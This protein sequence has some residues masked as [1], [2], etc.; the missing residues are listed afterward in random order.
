[1]SEKPTDPVDLYWGEDSEAVQLEEHEETGVP[2][3]AVPSAPYAI[4]QDNVNEHNHWAN[5]YV[6]MIGR[7]DL[8]EEEWDAPGDDSEVQSLIDEFESNLEAGEYGETQ[9]YL[10][11][12]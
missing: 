4:T 12:L 6:A 2:I 1:M 9:D 8:L 10:Q 3:A 5:A 7:T 11:D